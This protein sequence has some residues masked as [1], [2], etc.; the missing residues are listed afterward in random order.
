M[1]FSDH[2]DSLF[3]ETGLTG[4]REYLEKRV[5]METL[6]NKCL[7]LQSA[8]LTEWFQANLRNKRP[9]FVTLY[10]SL[11]SLDQKL[12]DQ[13]VHYML[14]NL[15]QYGVWVLDFILASPYYKANNLPKNLQILISKKVDTSGWPTELKK[16]IIYNDA[17]T[18]E[19]T[20]MAASY[21]SSDVLNYFITHRATLSPA[22]LRKIKS[23]AF[24]TAIGSAV[25]TY[26]KEVPEQLPEY[27]S[28]K[29][30]YLKAIQEQYSSSRRY[31]WAHALDIYNL[32][33][34]CPE[35]VTLGQYIS[36]AY[37]HSTPSSR[38]DFVL[39]EELPA[40][41]NVY[42]SNLLGQ[43]IYSMNEITT[44][45]ISFLVKTGVRFPLQ[46]DALPFP[47][48]IS[49]YKQEVVFSHPGVPL[50]A[51]HI[52][53]TLHREPI[54]IALSQRFLA[55]PESLKSYPPELQSRILATLMSLA[56]ASSDDLNLSKML[57]PENINATVARAAIAGYL[58]LCLDVMIPFLATKNLKT[59]L[60]HAFEST[61]KTCVLSLIRAGA[62]TSETT[63]ISACKS[64]DVELVETL[65]ETNPKLNLSAENQKAFRTA[66]V[67]GSPRVGKLLSS[68]YNPVLTDPL[69]QECFT[70]YNRVAQDYLA[71]A[72]TT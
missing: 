69:L 36:R 10:L 52:E 9:E 16:F 39:P 30:I 62:P 48:G 6:Q 35:K 11:I 41:D 43:M 13:K 50:T 59:L 53:D 45:D 49:T 54:R 57:T 68:K 22:L 2:L 60:N 32:A 25:T 66:I 33:P 28:N 42:N 67:L 21:F 15:G 56:G 40:W 24:S 27:L 8:E 47:L 29:N 23:L 58:P 38:A 46:T 70:A 26:F 64:L 44:N 14:S 71:D 17:P 37:F 4:V 12:L 51:T 18:P 19:E 5:T 55:S 72:S 31:N 7:L 1:Q 34:S 65:L 3:I 61:S 20:I 63:L